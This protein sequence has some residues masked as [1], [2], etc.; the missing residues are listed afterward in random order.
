MYMKKYENF[1]ENDLSKAK[2]C[3]ID[4]NGNIYPV[5]FSQHT[6]FIIDLKENY[7]LDY[8]DI[9]IDNKW[10]KVSTGCIANAV[11]IQSWAKTLTAKQ[12]ITIQKILEHF[13]E[14]L[15]NNDEMNIGNGNFISKENN[16]IKFFKLKD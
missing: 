8:N 4:T 7:E 13:P 3:W 2:N 16:K 6:N 14:I 15:K 5:L 12:K 11:L 10:V 1:I 9:D